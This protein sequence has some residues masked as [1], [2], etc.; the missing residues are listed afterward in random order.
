MS[1]HAMRKYLFVLLLFPTLVFGQSNWSK[2]QSFN[3]VREIKPP[4]LNI[5]NVEFS[6]PGGNNAIDANEKS[7]LRFQVT[8]SGRGDG[9][10]CVARISATGTRNALTFTDKKLYKIPAGQTCQVVIPISA[11]MAT[12]NGTVDFAISIDEGQGFGTEPIFLSVNTRQFDPPML[13]VV[14]YTI[15][16]TSSAAK[17]E[18]RVPFDLQ[19]LLQNTQYGKAENVKVNLSL[20]EGVM[21]LDQVDTHFDVIKAGEKKSIVFPLI[22]MVNYNSDV[23]PVSISISELYGKYAENRTISLKLNQTLSNNKIAIAEKVQEREDIVIGSLTSSVDKNIPSSKLSNSKTFAVIIAN[24]NYQNTSAVPYAINDGN[25]F[26]EYCEKT[27]GIPS[28]NIHFVPDAT[29]NNIRGEIAWLEN[30]LKSYEGDAKAILYYAGHGVPDVASRDSYLLP[31][32]GIGTNPMTGFKLDRMYSILGSLPSESITVFL[33]A[34]FSGADRS[35]DMVVRGD[36]GV[37]VKAKSSA[38]KGNVVVFSAAQGDETATPYAE[39]SH[40]MFTFYLLKKL[41]ET[42]GEVSYQELGEY[43]TRNVRQQSSVLGKPQTPAVIPSAAL[44]DNWKEWRF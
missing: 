23:I 2:P 3:I 25:I 29:L 42:A 17:L 33:D 36:R 34:C 14:D 27:L 24:E 20:P 18:K 7:T 1:D 37:A 40:G 22:A 12:V 9:L 4:V 5:T 11:G 32:D 31:V 19:I 10:D 26:K 8:N 30:V 41:Q 38:P 6:E 13:K 43:I 16:G 39:E 15:T 44:G 21:L 35:G 28:R